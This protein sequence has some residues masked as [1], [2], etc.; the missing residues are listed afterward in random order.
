MQEGWLPLHWSAA[1]QASEA[2]VAALLK[3]Y[4]E[5]AKET[6]QVCPA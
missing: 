6:D 3:A 4:L 5:A 1:N 2:V